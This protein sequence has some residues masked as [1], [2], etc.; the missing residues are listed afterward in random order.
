M[1]RHQAVYAAID[2]KVQFRLVMVLVPNMLY[3]AID[4]GIR[5]VEFLELIKD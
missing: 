4:A 5:P 1:K 3:V 2:D